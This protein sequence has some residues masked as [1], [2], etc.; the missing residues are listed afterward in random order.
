MH[1]RACARAF[2]LGEER[3]CVEEGGV[4][5]DEKKLPTNVNRTNSVCGYW[6]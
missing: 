5:V 2:R 6:P 1:E 3:A 4:G